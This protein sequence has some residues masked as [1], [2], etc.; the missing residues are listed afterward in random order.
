MS[1][2]YDPEIKK[3]KEAHAQDRFVIMHYIYENQ[4]PDKPVLS[5]KDGSEKDPDNFFIKVHREHVATEG[6]ELIK[7]MLHTL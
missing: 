5:I 3:W 6:H 4:N 2:A 1:V 7:K